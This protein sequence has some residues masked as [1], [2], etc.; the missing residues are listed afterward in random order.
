LVCGEWFL[1]NHFVVATA[2]CGKIFLLCYDVLWASVASGATKYFLFI[3]IGSWVSIRFVHV[4][5]LTVIEYWIIKQGGFLGLTRTPTLANCFLWCAL[6]LLLFL[7]KLFNLL[8][9]LHGIIIDCTRNSIT[10]F[11]PRSVM[12]AYFSATVVTKAIK[13]SIHMIV[14]D[15]FQ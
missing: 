9:L 6:L 4:A 3:L 5:V 10:Y 11:V 13:R 12:H 14:L 2:N 15:V 8:L 7:L 1:T